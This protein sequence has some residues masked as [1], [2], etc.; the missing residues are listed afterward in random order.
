MTTKTEHARPSIEGPLG[1]LPRLDNARV[2]IEPRTDM[3]LIGRI[4][5][6][7]PICYVDY[8][9]KS[10]TINDDRI[11]YGPL[12]IRDR[13]AL[14]LRAQKLLI[15]VPYRTIGDP[16]IVVIAQVGDGGRDKDGNP[17]LTLRGYHPGKSDPT[18]GEEQNDRI[19]PAID[20]PDG[21]LPRFD[22]VALSIEPYTGILN[23]T[24]L[25]GNRPMSFVDIT[26]KTRVIKGKS[27]TYGPLRDG[28]MVMLNL[29]TQELVTGAL[30]QSHLGDPNLVVVARVVEGGRDAKGY[31]HLVLCGYPPIGH[32]GEEW[33]GECYSRGYPHGCGAKLVPGQAMI[34]HWMS[35][36]RIEFDHLCINCWNIAALYRR[37]SVCHEHELAISKARTFLKI[38]PR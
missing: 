33:E 1:T 4:N 5:P 2:A 24:R 29:R 6:D 37:E 3:L 9:G 17:R 8:S 36:G 13:I 11:A 35:Q 19:L 10:H 23:L 7:I 26:G 38:W 14:D 31:P 20:G 25:D 32:K 16:N 30:L 34:M 15:V 28:D 21:P 22:N 12:R 18:P 27:K